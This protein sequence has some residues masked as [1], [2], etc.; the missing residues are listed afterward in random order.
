MRLKSGNTRERGFKE[1][2]NVNIRI[3][4]GLNKHYN[5]TTYFFTDRFFSFK[6]PFLVCDGQ[7]AGSVRNPSGWY[8]GGR[9]VCVTMKE[10]NELVRLH[11]A[12]SRCGNNRMVTL[13]SIWTQ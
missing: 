13:V 2:S 3:K 11:V 6:K 4:H 5:Q 8:G 9:S 12:S 7:K 1:T 10:W